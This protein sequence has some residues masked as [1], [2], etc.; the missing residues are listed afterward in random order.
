MA[1]EAGLGSFAA[2]LFDLSGQVALVTGAGQGLGRQMARALG[3]AG[4]LVVLGGRNGS[5]LAE[6][7]RL[8]GE[9]GGKA[10]PMPFD[11]DDG[12]AVAAALDG[13]VARHGR[14]DVL[15]NN[16]AVRNRGAGFAK[17]T[18]E[19]F[20]ALL[21]TNLVAATDLA[22]RAARVMM[23]GGQGGRIINIG[24]MISN[25][26]D[27]FD[28]SYAASKAGLA[29]MTRA[30]AAEYGPHAITVNEI[31]PGTFAT[32]YNAG[33][34]ANEKISASAREGAM[35]RRWAEPEEIAAAALFLASPGAS[36]ITGVQLLVDGGFSVKA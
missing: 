2:R 7:A 28:P 36:F 27:S 14:L 29:A 8:I 1:S 31:A 17:L 13:I 22:N 34:L 9:E 16:A 18:R 25:L 21:R 30:L 5:A 6:S 33:I 12:S 3:S 11:I 10:E 23:A 4:A 19:S 20:E 35:L 24:S 32:E 15:I 26:G